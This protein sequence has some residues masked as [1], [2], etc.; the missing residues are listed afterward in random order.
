MRTPARR[1]RGPSRS[2]AAALVVLLGFGALL[3]AVLRVG[4]PPPAGAAPA[5]GGGEMAEAVSSL[6]PSHG[7]L[8]DARP[9]VLDIANG[10]AAPGIAMAGG[11]DPDEVAV[12]RAARVSRAIDLLRYSPD[13]QPLR[14][15][16]I[17]V[18]APNRRHES[19][20]PLA[21]ATGRAGDPPKEGDLSFVLTG[22]VYAVVG[23]GALAVT[24]EVFR[25]STPDGKRERVAV[26]VQRG[27]L[28]ALE[29]AGSLAI[30]ATA[31][32]NDEGRDGDATAGDKIYGLS[33]VPAAVSALASYRGLVRLDVDFTATEGE[34]R[35]ARASLDFRVAGRVPALVT[36]IGSERLTPDGLE[37]AVDLRVDEPGHYFV[38][39]LIFDA[40]GDPIGLAVARPRLGAGSAR[41]PVLFWG[42]LFREAN[43]AGPY[44]VRT[45]TG[46]RL[47]EPIQADRADM[48]TWEGPYRTRAY[49]LSDFSD[50]EY[51]SPSKDLKLAALA[52]L[53]ARHPSHSR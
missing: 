38:Q 34:R 40:I 20:M 6:P 28:S 53:A 36:G 4:A 26:D 14:R 24:L 10:A 51:E 41:V 9:S 18:L 2:G 17:D 1:A 3:F 32:L 5:S 44:L 45:V 27:S 25:E 12:Q 48:A 7:D 47:P 50:K 19:A 52:A 15:D 42:L 16:M 23:S 8:A 13:S 33:L 31:L 35:P 49:A 37:V 21:M 22:D 11:H 29:A 46:Q 39:A 30:G 43:A